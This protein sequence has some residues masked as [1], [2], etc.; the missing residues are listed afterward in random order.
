MPLPLF[1]CS[2]PSV[3][4]LIFNYHFMLFNFLSTKVKVQMFTYIRIATSR[5]VTLHPH[6]SG[7]K[8]LLEGEAQQNIHQ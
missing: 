7:Q 2:L 3:L 5:V 4:A 8:E 6:P 1:L